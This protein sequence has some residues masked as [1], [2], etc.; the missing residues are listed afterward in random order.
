MTACWHQR[1][2]D[3]ELPMAFFIRPQ[4]A[5]AASRTTIEYGQLNLEAPQDSDWAIVGQPDL[6][7]DVRENGGI[8]C[9]GRKLCGICTIIAELDKIFRDPAYYQKFLA[10]RDTSAQT[11]LDVLQTLLD[12]D[13][14]FTTDTRRR[15]VTALR[16]LSADSDLHPKCFALSGIKQGTHVTGG[17]FGDV[18]FVFVLNTVHPTGNTG[19][20]YTVAE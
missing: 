3:H 1:A 18:L 7:P 13:S 5:K 16:R 20:I 6:E 12:Y 4:S 11:L 14:Y 9:P 15:F 17:T 19:N 10:R 8:E 2:S